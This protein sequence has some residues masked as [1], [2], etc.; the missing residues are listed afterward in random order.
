MELNGIDE[1]VIQYIVAALHLGALVVKNLNP[2]FEATPLIGLDDRADVFLSIAREANQVVQIHHRH[3][4][5]LKHLSVG[6]VSRAGENH[7]SHG[8][9][10]SQKNLAD[11]W[12]WSFFL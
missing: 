7:T 9:T 3:P 2:F 6:D 5:A 4:L 8:D 12:A 11:S 10:R 1:R